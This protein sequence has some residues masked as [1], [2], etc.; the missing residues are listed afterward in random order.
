[1]QEHF[2]GTFEDYFCLFLPSVLNAQL[3]SEELGS[4]LFLNEE[5]SEY[6]TNELLQ[7]FAC[8]ENLCVFCMTLKVKQL[9]RV[10]IHLQQKSL[11]SCFALCAQQVPRP[12]AQTKSL[13]FATQQYDFRGLLS[14]LLLQSPV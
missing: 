8:L 9:F 4:Y 2:E 13:F 12:C 10:G 5:S 6:K 7:T 14:N 11:C 1:M 3:C